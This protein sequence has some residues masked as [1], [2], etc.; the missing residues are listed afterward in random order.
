MNKNRRC[1]RGM[2]L[3]LFFFSAVSFAQQEKPLPNRQRVRENLATL[4]LL[5]LTQALDL[6]ED[7]AAKIFPTVNKIEKEKLQLQ[8]RMSADIRD[9][10]Q[11]LID[12]PSSEAEIEAMVAKIREAQKLVREKDAELESFLESS[13]TG[14]QKAKYVIFQIEF[15]RLMD[16]TL[17]RLRMPRNNPASPP[18]KK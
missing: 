6:S 13:L 7:Q 4:R 15:Y 14:V 10:R 9:L 12:P 5:R 11:I 17:D 18:I 16:Q 3:L 2:G 8:R 1:I